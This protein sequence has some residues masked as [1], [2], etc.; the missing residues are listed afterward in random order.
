MPC[1]ECTVPFNVFSW[2]HECHSCSHRFC[3]L[4]ITKKHFVI[5]D[6]G[7]ET[8]A[9]CAECA[10]HDKK[11]KDSGV[12]AMERCA[13]FAFTK[14]FKAGLNRLLAA[15]CAE[16]YTVTIK[17]YAAQLR[18]LRLAASDC[19]PAQACADLNR[20]KLAFS[21]GVG[22]GRELQSPSFEALVSE[23]EA[24]TTGF[25]AA[26]AVSAA[27]LRQLACKLAVAAN[28]SSS[29]ADALQALS[30]LLT[31]DSDPDSAATHEQRLRPQTM[32]VQRASAP[33][34][35]AVRVRIE[36]VAKRQRKSD[37]TGSAS[38]TA[39]TG[40]QAKV[41]AAVQVLSG[42]SLMLSVDGNGSSHSGGDDDEDDDDEDDDEDAGENGAG[43]AGAAAPAPGSAALVIT[44]S[45]LLR[46]RLLDVGGGGGGG[47]GRVLVDIDAVVAEKFTVTTSAAD[48]G[49]VATMVGRRMRVQIPD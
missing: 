2:S 31:L 36:R 42:G 16:A 38:V 39:I 49:A 27:S 23:L 11:S 14:E 19:E 28:R 26:P 45:T 18:A 20:E 47:G 12:S 44:V 29:G 48:Q 37:S 7:A 6:A 8:L 4:H 30:K 21:G 5:A 24:R 41:K 46:F 13:Y 40:A 17:A 34:P 15:G 22:D 43:G 10:A 35:P 1:A 9:L 32:L 25:A 3:H 33:P